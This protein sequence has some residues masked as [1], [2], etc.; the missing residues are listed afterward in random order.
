[1]TSQDLSFRARL[2]KRSLSF[3]RILSHLVI[4]SAARNL[5]L[6]GPGRSRFLAALGMTKCK[7]VLV[8]ITQRMQARHFRAEPNTIPS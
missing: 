6:D 1:M 4:P 3:E 7:C 8:S 2:V 5:S